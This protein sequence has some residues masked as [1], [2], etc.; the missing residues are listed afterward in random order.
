MH[1]V[2]TGFT[3]ADYCRAMERREIIVNKEYQRSDKV[4]PLCTRM[5][6]TVPT[7][8]ITEEGETG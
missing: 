7:P 4:W 8:E 5:S 3:V 1:I 2:I 6:E